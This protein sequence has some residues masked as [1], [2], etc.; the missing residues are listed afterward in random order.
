M[1]LEGFDEV[2]LVYDASDRE[3]FYTKGSFYRVLKVN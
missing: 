3:L 2:I 1:Y